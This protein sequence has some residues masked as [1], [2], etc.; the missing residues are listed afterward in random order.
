MGFAGLAVGVHLP[1]RTLHALPLFR[2]SSVPRH[3]M[4]LRGFHPLR[5]PICPCPQRDLPSSPPTWPWARAQRRAPAVIQHLAL[6]TP[7]TAQPRLTSPMTPSAS[8]TQRALRLTRS[9]ATTSPRRRH[10]SVDGN[11][12]LGLLPGC[13]SA[14]RGPPC[15]LASQRCLAC[16]RYVDLGSPTN[17]YGV[18][19]YFRTDC[20]FERNAD[21]EVRLAAG[22]KRKGQPA[23]R[24]S[25]RQC[26]W[27]LV[28]RIWAGHL[29]TTNRAW[30]HRHA[31]APGR[32]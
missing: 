32:H 9:G 1:T 24:L 3:A 27:V 23:T 29:C 19:I 7:W 25:R 18:R 2:H 28:P 26:L 10:A 6:K 22:H 21:F 20:C 30:C 4:L 14:S 13:I 31:G 5:F 8:P 12:P 15:P 17:V 11:L 16:R